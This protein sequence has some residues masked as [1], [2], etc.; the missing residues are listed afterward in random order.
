VRRIIGPR[1]EEVTRK[2]RK[3]HNEELTD[4]YSTKYYSGDQIENGM[5]GACRMYEGKERCIEGIGGET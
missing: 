4:M 5:S 1:R 3:L 2:W